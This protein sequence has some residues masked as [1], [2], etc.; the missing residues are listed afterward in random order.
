MILPDAA[1]EADILIA[2][3]KIAEVIDYPN[4]A[5]RRDSP[6]GPHDYSASGCYVAP[7]FIDIHTQ[8][9][10]GIDMATAVGEEIPRMERAMLACGTTGYL[11]TLAYEAGV[12][13]GLLPWLH[14]NSGGAKMLGLYL[15][16][17]FINP[18]R[19]GAIPSIYCLEPDLATLRSILGQAQ[20]HLKIMTIAPELEGSLKLIEELNKAGV[21]PSI[22]HTQATYD[23]AVRGIEAGVC[24]TTHLFNA[25]TGIN[26]REPGAAGAVLSNDA[27]TAELIA[28]GIHVHLAVLGM[29]IGIKGAENVAVITDAAP[30]AGLPPNGR[31]EFL[32]NGVTIIDGA[33]RLPDGTLAGSILTPIKALENLVRLVGLPVH[34]AV[35]MLTLTP[36][37]IAGVASCK[38][39]LEQGKDADIVV[40]NDRFEV[41]ATFVGGELA[42]ER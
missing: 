25:M 19:L 23:Q 1:V 6:Q 3:G 34:T 5:P 27:V 17:P 20:G 16:G 18:R 4:G 36:A 41:Q 10:A 7:G 31:H 40:F 24:H 8:G 39:S 32:G 37:A 33:P 11:A 38:G 12:F 2:D 9:F 42:W 15:E 29:A 22:G 13:D 26:H 30:A 35:R 21:T 28:D 14:A